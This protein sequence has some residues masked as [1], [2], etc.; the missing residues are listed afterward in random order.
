MKFS[1]SEGIEQLI[2]TFMGSE[3]NSE[4]SVMHCKECAKLYQPMLMGSLV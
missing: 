4:P 1:G 3:I 2:E